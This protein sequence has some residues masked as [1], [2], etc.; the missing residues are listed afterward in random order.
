[1]I[2]ILQSYT[3]NLQTPTLLKKITSMVNMLIINTEDYKRI[4]KGLYPPPFPSNPKKKRLGPIKTLVTRSS[5]TVSSRGHK[6]LR[7]TPIP[8]S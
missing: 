6:L 3:K 1:M 8:V 7:I 5:S 4:Q 2:Q